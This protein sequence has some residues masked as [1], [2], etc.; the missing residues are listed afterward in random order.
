MMNLITG[1]ARFG[2]GGDIAELVVGVRRCGT[3]MKGFL[4]QFGAG[5]Q[6]GIEPG[7]ERSGAD[8][9]HPVH[10]VVLVPFADV[11]A[12]GSWVTVEAA[13]AFMRHLACQQIGASLAVGEPSV[14]QLI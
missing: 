4:D 9:G 6:P 13:S 11:P 8:P 12:A 7:R 10:R 1:S 5:R 2:D 14:G 3:L